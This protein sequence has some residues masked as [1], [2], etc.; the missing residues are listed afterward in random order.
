MRELVLGVYGFGFGENKEMMMLE[1]L[2][3][4]FRYNEWA[5]REVIASFK[6]AGSPPPRSLKLMEHV[7]GTEWFFRIEGGKSSFAVWR[8]LNLAACEEH[9]GHLRT[10]WSNY[11]DQSTPERLSR[12][13]TYKNSKGET[14]RNSVEDILMHVVMHSAYHRGQI[15]ADMRAAGHTPAYTDFIHRARQKMVD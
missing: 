2:R 14:W 8:D 1:H 10:M 3:R 11:L 13:V 6:A 4:L 9:V 5:N 15:A 12:A 7:L